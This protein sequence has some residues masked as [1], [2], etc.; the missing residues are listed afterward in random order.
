MLHHQSDISDAACIIIVF[1][2]ITTTYL[3]AFVCAFNSHRH[4]LN[5]ALYC[6]KTW[7]I[8]WNRQRY[9]CVIR[10]EECQT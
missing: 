6:N 10:T 1:A 4:Q 5:V 7:L 3:I 2:P 8:T 9:H